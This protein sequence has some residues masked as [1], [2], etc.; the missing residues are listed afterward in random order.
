MSSGNID[1]A[2]LVWWGLI[3]FLVFAGAAAIV[4]RLVFAWRGSGRGRRLRSV[5]VVTGLHRVWVW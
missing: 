2:P 5:S 3:V 1:A 4:I